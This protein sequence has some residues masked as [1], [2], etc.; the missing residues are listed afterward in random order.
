[1]FIPNSK[2]LGESIVNDSL[3][4]TVQVRTLTVGVSY[5]V[6]PNKV[7][8]AILEVLSAVPR[9]LKY[10]APLV[11][12]ANYGDFAIQF[13][14]RYPI[15]DFAAHADIGSEILNLLWYKFKRSEIEIPYP[16]RNVQ[17]K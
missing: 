9:V 1:M 17:L 2:V 5:S 13:E 11:R 16:V 6:P 8:T 4:D 14:I 3:P 15:N 10:P 12:V 7:K